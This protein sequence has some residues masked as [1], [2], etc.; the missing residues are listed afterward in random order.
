MLC[1]CANRIVS[2][3]EHVT[4]VFADNSFAGGYLLFH[5]HFNLKLC[6]REDPQRTEVLPFYLFRW[7]TS[8]KR[9]ILNHSE[10]TLQINS[11]YCCCS[12]VSTNE[13]SQTFLKLL[14]QQKDVDGYFHCFTFITPAI[15][16]L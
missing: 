6:G 8:D 11:C 10:L 2:I 12:Y 13:R 5:I 15:K 7:L 1:S 16:A 3:Q 14:S 9:I 4:V